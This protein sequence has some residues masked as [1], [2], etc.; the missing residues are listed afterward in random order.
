[1]YQSAGLNNVVNFSDT[2]IKY[3]IEKY[4][5]EAGVRKLKENLFEI[6]SEINLKLLKNED[7]L[8][9]LPFNVTKEAIKRI[10]LKDKH[11]IRSVSYTHLTLP[12]K[13]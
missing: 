1:M 3:I 11:K 7:A 6:I 13:A 8:V 4:T 9:E 2:I 5:R 12:T 10:F